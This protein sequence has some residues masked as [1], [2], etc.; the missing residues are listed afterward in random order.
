MTGQ[1]RVRVTP[2]TAW[3]LATTSLPSSSMSAASASA[4]TSYGPLTT[5]DEK[6]LSIRA[7]SLVTLAELPTWTWTSTY[8]LIMVSTYSM[9]EPPRVSWRL[10]TV[11]GWSHDHRNQVSAGSA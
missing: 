3:I 9:S 5:S 11:R 6:T 7:I 4:M 2:S 10:P 8:A 1:V